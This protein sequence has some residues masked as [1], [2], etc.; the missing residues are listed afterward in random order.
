MKFIRTILRYVVS[1][2]SII[3]TLIGLILLA[4]G[5]FNEIAGNDTTGEFTFGFPML[6]I[7]LV[8]D[9]MLLKT[10]PKHYAES[11]FE[12]A[13]NTLFWFFIN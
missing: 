8:I 9:F 11:T 3:V 1:P 13:S 12:Y 4:I 5:I 7:G 10:Q 2:H 6:A